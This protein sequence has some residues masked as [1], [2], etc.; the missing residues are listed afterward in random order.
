MA[1]QILFTTSALI[2]MIV[3][4]NFGNLIHTALHQHNSE[5]R[6]ILNITQPLNGI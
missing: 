2:S 5:L 3:L 6:C 1:T 4:N